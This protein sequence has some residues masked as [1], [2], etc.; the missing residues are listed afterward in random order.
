MASGAVRTYAELDGRS[1]RLAHGL[2]AMGC[3]PGDRVGIWLGN[4]LEYLDVYLACAKAGLVVVPV[5]GRFTPVEADHVL[6]DADVRL[7]VYCSEIAEQ[8]ATLEHRP[9]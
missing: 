1:Q 8:V 3:T 5:N 4:C 6:G 9:M 2:L 7:L